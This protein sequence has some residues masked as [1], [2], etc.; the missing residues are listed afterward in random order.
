MFI[1]RPPMEIRTWVGRRPDA[2]F[3]AGLFG[4]SKAAQ[5]DAWIVNKRAFEILLHQLNVP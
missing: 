4:P 5:G 1:E 2:W 3:F